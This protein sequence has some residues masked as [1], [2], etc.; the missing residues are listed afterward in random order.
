MA[1]ISGQVAYQWEVFIGPTASSVPAHILTNTFD[2][3]S[4]PIKSGDIDQ[5]LDEDRAPR[6]LCIVDG[7]LERS[8]TIQN[9]EIQ[10]ALRAG[11]PV[12]GV[13]SVGALKA[14]DLH[15]CGMQGFGWVYRFLRFHHIVAF[16]ELIS[17]H[18]VD[19]PYRRLSE[20]LI[21][22]RA[23]LHSLRRNGEIHRDIEMSIASEMQ[24]YWFGDRTIRKLKGALEP[25]METRRLSEILASDGWRVKKRDF[26]NFCAQKMSRGLC[27]SIRP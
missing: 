24:S 13:S 16:D 17:M 3:I 7:Y 20:S 9:S 8:T 26:S 4:G 22:I 5:R 6:V 15:G 10:R 19:W 21:E 18:A 14:A 23:L 1:R 12:W 11:W 27:P 2:R 25:I